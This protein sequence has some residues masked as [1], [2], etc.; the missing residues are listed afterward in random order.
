MAVVEADGHFFPRL[1]QSDFGNEAASLIPTV[2]EPDLQALVTWHKIT[3]SFLRANPATFIWFPDKNLGCLDFP[4]LS[5][6]V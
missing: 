1:R 3:Q 4:P 6:T 2:F 5:L